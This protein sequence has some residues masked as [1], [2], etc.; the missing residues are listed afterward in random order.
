[1]FDP[2]IFENLKVAIENQVYDLDNITGQIQI[3]NRIDRL[4]MAV[5]AREFALR[6][7]LADDKEV[8]AEICLEAS[9]QDLASEILEMPGENPGCTLR[10][11][12]YMQIENVDV[13][14]KQIEE[15]LMD[16]W[17]P[18]QPPIQ[19]LSYVYGQEPESYLNTAEIK[20]NRKINED[21]MGDISELLDYMVRSLSKLRTVQK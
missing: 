9:L 19:T 1:M 2:T 21:Q 13:Q 10:I 6:F 17:Q 18:E 4:E 8:S 15:I 5:M 20:F 3:I 16:I 11:R 7:T 12:F 14:C